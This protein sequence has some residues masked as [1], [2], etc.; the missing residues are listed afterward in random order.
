MDGGEGVAHILKA[1]GS[2]G[3]FVAFDDKGARGFIEFVGM[4]S[5]HTRAVFAK[6]QREAMKGMRRA[7]PDIAIRSRG[8]IG[9]EAFLILRAHFA[10]HAIGAYDKIVGIK[11]GKIVDWSAKVKRDAKLAAPLLENS[12][13]FN[14]R[15][16]RKFI[17]ANGNF[18][19]MV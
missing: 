4:R 12:Q 6:R 18:L 1:C 7:I 11:F 13:N 2:P 17:A 14:S 9:F 15:Y 8:K 5:E 10:H 3:F 16:A 19:I